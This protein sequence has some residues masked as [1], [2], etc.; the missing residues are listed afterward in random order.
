M[1][2]IQLVNHKAMEERRR[3]LFCEGKVV[4]CSWVS[5]SEYSARQIHIRTMLLIEGPGHIACMYVIGLESRGFSSWVRQVLEHAYF[6][7]A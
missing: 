6:Y 5:V 1:P 4:I 2:P 7:Y 3:C